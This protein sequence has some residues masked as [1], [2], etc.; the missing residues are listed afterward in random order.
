MIGIDLGLEI[1]SERVEI[2]SERANLEEI[3]LINCEAVSEINALDHYDESGDGNRI[4][5]QNRLN[6][7]VKETRPVGKRF[8]V[9]CSLGVREIFLEGGKPEDGPEVLLRVEAVYELAYSLGSRKGIR[10]KDILSFAMLNGH[11]DAWPFWREMA[12]NL[13]SRM[14]RTPLSLDLKPPDRWRP[15]PLEIYFSGND[16]DFYLVVAKGADPRAVVPPNVLGEMGQLVHRRHPSRSGPDRSLMDVDRGIVEEAVEK[17]GY[18][19]F[20]WPA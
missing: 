14:G 10:K 4:K 2:I 3:R 18:H 17:S 11:R 16:E 19:V 9:Y 13:T 1:D 6:T 5:R 15:K 7:Q 12:H 20:R 8:W